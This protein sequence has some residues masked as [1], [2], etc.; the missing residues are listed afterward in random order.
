MTGRPA[1]NGTRANNQQAAQ[2]SFPHLRGRTQLLLA[3]PRMLERGQ[4]QLIGPHWVVRV[5]SLWVHSLPL[6][7]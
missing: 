2:G 4:P 1:Q 7:A 6:A 3:A 5:E